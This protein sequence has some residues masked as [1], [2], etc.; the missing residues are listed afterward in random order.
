MGVSMGGLV[1]RIALRQMELANQNHQT[2]KYISVDSPHKG[3]NVPVGFQAAVR[4]LQNTNLEV[5]FFNLLDYTNFDMLKLPVDLLNSTAA[6]QMLIYY[7]DHNY[8][9]DNTVHNQ[10]QAA[11]DNLGFPQGFP[12]QP[13]E[14]IAISNGSATGTPNFAPGSAIIDYQF[15]YHFKW[16]MDILS[17]LAFKYEG[18]FLF[19]NYPQLFLNVIPGH[20]EVKAEIEIN[21]LGNQSALEVYHGHIYIRKK[22]L[23][24][25]NA[26]INIKNRPL[27]AL[28][29]C[30]L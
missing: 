6:K 12:S 25:I 17:T 20:S 18:F 30:C 28:P 1:A 8:N 14:N 29:A 26:N 16:W 21:A 7:V 4:H 11:C 23:W 3:A 15:S 9:F 13:I 2:W 19:T 24:T 27:T 10:F 5:M 22:I